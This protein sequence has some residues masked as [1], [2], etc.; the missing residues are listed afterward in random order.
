MNKFIGTSRPRLS[1]YLRLLATK[2]IPN[3]RLMKI[4]FHA[5]WKTEIDAEVSFWES[6]LRTGGLEWTDDF[7]ERLDPSSVLAHDVVVR[8]LR[9]TVQQSVTILDVGAG[10]LTILGKTFPGK[11]LSITAVDPLAEHYSRLL[12]RFGIEPPVRT[13]SG[14]GERL[15]DLFGSKSFDIA[16]AQNSL[17]HSYDPILVIENMLE[18]VK[19]S[20]SVV[21]SHMRNEA[22]NEGYA[23]LH[24]WNFD[25]KSGDLVLW[26]RAVEHN[27]SKTFS[28]AA[29]VKP[30]LDR[31][32]G[33]WVVNCV[34]ARRRDWEDIRAAG[35][36]EA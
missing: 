4:L 17:D 21:L 22:E 16:F 15:L 29:V 13:V 18:V 7:E 24:Q 12:N 28:P 11:D 3:Q 14:H 32:D 33:D 20:G 35:D 27:V 10:P 23:G 19:G 34:I 1:S 5:L 25:V 31:V 30:S 36:Q 6:W 9:E 8:I 26:N 2:P